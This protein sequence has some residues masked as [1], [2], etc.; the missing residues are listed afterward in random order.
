MGCR[1]LSV[2]ICHTPTP[3]PAPRLSSRKSQP[4]WKPIMAATLTPVLWVWPN[5]AQVF[6]PNIH[7]IAA[8]I[9]A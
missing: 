9:K 7:P 8:I 2:W 1:P 3:T 5:L 4:V 6:N